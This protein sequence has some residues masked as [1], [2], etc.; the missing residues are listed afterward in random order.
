M[1]GRRPDDGVAV[2]VASADDDELEASLQEYN[3]ELQNAVQF[4]F[5][6]APYRSVSISYFY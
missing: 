3:I 4:R 6:M 2:V 1:S 5:H